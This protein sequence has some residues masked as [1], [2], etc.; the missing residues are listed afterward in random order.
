[1]Q[2]PV[3]H[4][5]RR[6]GGGE[7]AGYGVWHDD[8]TVEVPKEFTVV[9]QNEVVQRA[10]VGDDDSSAGQNAKLAMRREVVFDIRLRV[11]K[12]HVMLL[13][14][15]VYLK[16]S[17]QFEE[18]TDLSL[19]KPTSPIA[20]NGDGFERAPRYV[21]TLRLEG[22]RNVLWQLGCDLHG[23]SSS[24]Y[25]RRWSGEGAQG[26]RIV[27][28][29][30][31]AGRHNRAFLSQLQPTRS[32]GEVK[33][34]EAFTKTFDDGREADFRLANRRLQ[35]LGHLTATRFLG[36]RQPL[37]YGGALLSPRLSLKLSLPT[38][39][40]DTETAQMCE[41]KEHAWKL[42]PLARAHAHNT[43]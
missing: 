4:C 19:G 6:T 35:P 13:E 3:A 9:E 14:Q 28:T 1:L 18:P 32:I 17:V 16:A 7:F 30:V 5:R 2:D 33:E 22:G 41:L 42:I 43:R 31:L 25:R 26:L 12:R 20:L 8:L 38:L 36:I 37:S 21:V 10:A 11:A 15:R 23:L 40:T 27:P 34:K 29:I 24:F 39:R